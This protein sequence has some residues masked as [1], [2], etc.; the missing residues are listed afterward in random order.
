MVIMVNPGPVARMERVDRKRSTLSIIRKQLSLDEAIVLGVI[1][2][3][4]IPEWRGAGHFHSPAPE[5]QRLPLTWI[6]L[7]EK[8]VFPCALRARAEY[9]KKDASN[10]IIYSPSVNWTSELI[11]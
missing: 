8:P 7:R 1:L 6:T 10:A 11:D 4:L 3:C 9:S 2:C 5:L